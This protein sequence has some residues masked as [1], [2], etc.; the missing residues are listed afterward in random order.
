MWVKLR[1]WLREKLVFVS[2]NSSY[3]LKE[4]EVK[5]KQYFKGFNSNQAS[6]YIDDGR[7]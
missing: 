3:S 1:V 4:Q 6:L 2:A 7:R 5:L